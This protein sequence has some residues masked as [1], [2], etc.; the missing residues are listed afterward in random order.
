MKLWTDDDGRR[1]TEPAYTISSPGA[2]GSGELKKTQIHSPQS[3]EKPYGSH[4]PHWVGSVEKHTIR[5]CQLCSVSELPSNKNFYNVTRF[6]FLDLTIMIEY[7]YF[8]K[9]TSYAV[10]HANF[11]NQEHKLKSY[12]PTSFCSYARPA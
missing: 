4:P 6:Y 2:F 7:E 5:K 11:T 3:P 9:C 1:T 8:S 12:S 10:I